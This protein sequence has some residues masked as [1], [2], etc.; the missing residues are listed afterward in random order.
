MSKQFTRAQLEPFVAAGYIKVE[1]HPE[2]DLYVYNYTPKT[3]YD[4][5]WTPETRAC[6]GLILDGTGAIAARP[7]EKFFNLA[8]HADQL[9]KEPFE[10]YEKLDGSLGISY[11]L[12]GRPYLA[13]RGSFVSEQARRGTRLLHERYG[14]VRLDPSLTYL[15]EVIY[16][17][18]RIVVDYADRED[19]VLLA[20]VE[21]STGR[22]V[23]L[24]DLGFPVAQRHDG[25]TDL[26]SLT[27]L[28]GT[29]R[30]GFVVRFASG[31]RVK[32]KL[33]EYVRLH[34]L[35]TGLSPK[36]VWELRRDGA[37]LDAV[38]DRVPD[39]FYAWVRE[40]AADL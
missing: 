17:E 11:W 14:H 25:L 28:V 24:V 35:L 40:V 6:R 5:H 12:E 13:T 15:F 38:L 39:E 10:V 16:P 21:T 1:R 27:S 30:E 34:R 22:E 2:A 19:L 7:F 32:V 33:D 9:P 26:E 8:E 37:N 20:I 18:N 3:Q 31:L 36:H 4:A 29:N 23:P